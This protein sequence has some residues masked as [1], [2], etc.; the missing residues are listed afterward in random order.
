MIAARRTKHGQDV[1][2]P[3]RRQYV[4]GLD[5]DFLGFGGGRKL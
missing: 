1:I 4:S 5:F 2:G 3:G